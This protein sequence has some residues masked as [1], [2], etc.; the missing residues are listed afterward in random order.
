MLLQY[1]IAQVNV[2]MNKYIKGETYGTNVFKLSLSE[3]Y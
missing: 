2:L 1:S 3:C